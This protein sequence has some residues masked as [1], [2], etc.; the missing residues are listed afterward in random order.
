[1]NYSQSN[2]EAV[3]LCRTPADPTRTLKLPAIL[4]HSVFYS[5]T[6]VINPTTFVDLFQ[7]ATKDPF[8]TLADTACKHGTYEKICAHFNT[9]SDF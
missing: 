7:D 6:A 3:N 2:T 8:G 1:M 4:N 9:R 5:M